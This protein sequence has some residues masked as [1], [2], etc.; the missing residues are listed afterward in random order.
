MKTAEALPYSKGNASA[1]GR[2]NAGLS[3]SSSSA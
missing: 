1:N 2:R 3:Y